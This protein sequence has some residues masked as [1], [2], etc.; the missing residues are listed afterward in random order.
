[1]SDVTDRSQLLIDSCLDWLDP[2]QAEAA[3]TAINDAPEL[4]TQSANLKRLLDELDTCEAPAPSADLAER[5]LARIE[6][7]ETLIPFPVS[8]AASAIPSGSEREFSGNPVLSLRE[9]ITIA[10]CITLFVGIFVPGYYK[11]QAI[12][13]RNVCRDNIRQQYAGFAAYAELNAGFLPYAGVVPGGSWL[14]VRVPGVLRASNTKHYYLAVKEG[15]V[16]ARAF[17]CPGLER[18]IPMTMESYRKA[19]DFAEPANCTY[20]F[21]NQNIPKP[22]PMNK[23]SPDMVIG[24]DPTPYFS[25]DVAHNLDPSEP[26]NSYSH[27]PNAGQN[28]VYVDGR[29]NWA[30]RPTVGVNEDN[31]YLAGTLRHYTGTEIPLYPTDSFLT[32]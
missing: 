5:V 7:S 26:S 23:L 21:Q 24:G 22:Q 28:V 17:V 20:S 13:R 18:G 31:I 32:P 15:Y 11:A 8:E 4:R 29:T 3:R 1:M 19:N 14:R 25:G 10:A 16:P 6:E 30:T 12:S 2:K 27:D 9:L